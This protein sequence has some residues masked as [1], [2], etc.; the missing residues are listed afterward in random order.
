[1]LIGNPAIARELATT[2][3]TNNASKCIATECIATECIATE[4]ILENFCF[5][6]AIILA[7]K[8]EF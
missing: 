4:C 7:S 1:M 5:D 2:V 8:I 3:P 6:T